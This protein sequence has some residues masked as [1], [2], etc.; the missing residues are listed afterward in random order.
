MPYYYN[1]MCM[2]ERYSMR[3]RMGQTST[4][5]MFSI[6]NF[7]GILRN[8]RAIDYSVFTTYKGGNET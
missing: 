6:L 1:T 2:R 8:G 4:E 3:L 5:S 7:I